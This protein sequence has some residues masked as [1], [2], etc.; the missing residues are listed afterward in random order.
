M[1]SI[2]TDTGP[3]YARA[4]EDDEWHDRARAF[5]ES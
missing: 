4:D 1:Q 3:L 2:L 5:L